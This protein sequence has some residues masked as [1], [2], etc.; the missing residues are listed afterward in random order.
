MASIVILALTQA[1]PSALTGIQDLFY[2]AGMKLPEG[3]EH[4]YSCDSLLWTPEIL[5]ASVD[6]KPIID[7]QGRSY[8]VEKSLLDIKQCDAILIPGF[9]PNQVS[10]PPLNL[11]DETT[12][13]WLKKQYHQ[14]AII[15]GSCSGVLAIGEAGL[16]DNRRCTTTWWLHDELKVRNPKTCPLWASELLVDKN[17]VSAGGPLSWVETTLQVVKML[18][19]NGVAKKMA[20]FAIL[21]TQPKSQSSSVPRGYKITQPAFVTQAELAIRQGYGQSMSPQQLAQ[22]MAVSERTLHRKLTSLTGLSPKRYID[23]VR[24]E[25]ACT[26]LVNNNMSISRV[27]LALGYSDDAVFR[28]VFKLVMRMTPSQYKQS[29]K[30]EGVE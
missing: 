26:L 2:L 15:A 6:G 12:K 21:D 14:G 19:G 24:I 16:L 8:Q 18:A 25:Y 10:V 29:M 28:R 7:G 22:A 11:L 4:A 3:K 20:D 27:A 5:V 9:V 17:I 23:Q 13:L 1:L 30:L